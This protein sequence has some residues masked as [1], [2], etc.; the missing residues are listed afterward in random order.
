[1]P[2][3]TARIHRGLEGGY[4]FFRRDFFAATRLRAAAALSIAK[5]SIL[6]PCLSRAASHRGRAPR[7]AQVSPPGPR[8]FGGTLRPFIAERRPPP[9][10]ELVPPSAP[11][12]ESC[13]SSSLRF[14]TSLLSISPRSV[15][16]ASTSIP[17]RFIAGIN[18]LPSNQVELRLIELLNRNA[19]TLKW[20]K[21][22]RIPNQ[23]RSAPRQKLATR[24]K[25]RT[26]AR[27]NRRQFLCYPRPGFRVQRLQQDRSVRAV[28]QARRRSHQGH[29]RRTQVMRAVGGAI[30]GAD[31]GSMIPSARMRRFAATRLQ[32]FCNTAPQFTHA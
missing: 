11:S 21:V 22:A 29:P 20:Y 9:P 24:H 27:F 1:M 3:R 6:R 5:S 18:G 7:P 10:R 26:A 4:Y 15:S 14:S 25:G 32:L 28:H 12:R 30:F 19:S 13:F 17:L 16:S 31:N 2:R 23:C 8:Y